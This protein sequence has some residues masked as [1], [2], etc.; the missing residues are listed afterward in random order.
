[1]F[2]EFCLHLPDRLPARLPGLGVVVAAAAGLAGLYT[3]SR[4]LDNHAQGNCLLGGPSPAWTQW[5]REIVLVTGGSSGIGRAIVDGFAGRGIRVVVWDLQAPKQ[6]FVGDVAFYRVD[7]TDDDAVHAAAARVR[8]DVGPPSVLINNAGYAHGL[9]L[10]DASDEQM[11][12]VFAVNTIAP[13]VLVREFLPAMI[14][15]DH[16]HI[17][18]MASL[19]SFGPIAGLTDYSGSKAAVLA[20]HEGLRQELKHRYGAP[21]V[22][23]SI[24]HPHWVRSPMTAALEAQGLRESIMEPEQVAAAVLALVLNGRSG[25]VLLPWYRQGDTVTR[26]LPVWMQE[27]LRDARADVMLRKK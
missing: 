22:Q 11:R 24:I 19:A 13:L 14:R 21:A 10:L 18:S 8:H 23:T 7:L 20:L 12:R 6:A 26:A 5:D 15:A 4:L 17:V 3:A 9:D 1:M 16:G 27:W 25:Q 2:S